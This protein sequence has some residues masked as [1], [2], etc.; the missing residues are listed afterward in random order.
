MKITLVGCGAMGAALAR[1]LSLAGHRTRVTDRD[2]DKA[3]ALAARYPGLEALAAGAALGDSD[4]VI[5]A[6]A[7]ADALAALR[8]LGDLRG[9]VLIDV[10]TPPQVDS[11]P[12][13]AET[14]AGA[15][16]GIALAKAF[17][18][19]SAQTLAEGP[20]PADGLLAQV[21]VASDSERA[22]QTAC[23]LAES[24]GF[25]PRDAGPLAHAR[26]LEALAAL[27]RY[28]D[29]G[30]GPAAVPAPAPREPAAQSA[31]WP[32]LFVSHGAPTFALE[33][34]AAGARLAALGREL[35]R[36]RAVLVVSPHWLSRG[37][38]RVGASA[39][40]ATVHDFGGFPEA[41]YR[42]QY[43][44]PGAPELA[45]EVCA[46]LA[47]AGWPASADAVRGLDHGAWVPLLHLLPAAEVPVLQVSL[48]WPLTPADAWRL[49]RDLAPLRE[50]GVLLLGSGS[51]T[52]NLHEFRSEHGEG[53]AYVRE[54]AAWIAATLEAHDLPALLDYRR[55][56][57][58]AERAHPTDEHLL[59][60][61]F[62]LGAA[63][64]DYRLQRL[65]GGIA[66]GVL[67][68][69]SFLFCAAAAAPAPESRRA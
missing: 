21:L 22:R 23:A 49:G 25:T 50:R 51:L 7:T 29:D 44:A 55:Q 36:P 52:H 13:A 67:A 26:H 18:T 66:Y 16:P 56:A 60:L 12:S 35:P 54:F 65:D 53:A 31:A 4:V 63:G 41:L 59:P 40:P 43:P 38:V 10:G 24:F 37:G 48:P 42:L 34:G 58:A 5:V 9:K 8:S 1:R 45:A 19:L 62:T 20:Q 47:D 69:D 57:P 68:M 32:V 6:T 30:A 46:L 28:L 61:F 64:A 27:N 39:R 17:N 14:L 3:H 11:G 15:L 33:P 2:L